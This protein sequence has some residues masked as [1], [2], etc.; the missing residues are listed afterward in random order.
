MNRTEFKKAIFATVVC[1]SLVW[2]DYALYGSLIS[3][4]SVL[5]FPSANYTTQIISAFGVFAVGFL[6]RPLGSLFFGHIGDKYGRRIA[7]FLS[8]ISMSLP[9][10]LIA[11]LPTYQRIGIA[12]TII[13]VIIRAIQGFS[14]GGEAGNAVYL[15]EYSPKNRRGFFGSFEV[16]SAV[17][18]ALLS[19]IVIAI[20]KF[21]I[22]EENFFNWGWRIPFGIG[23]I[24]GIFGTVLRYNVSETP[25][26][27]KN[28]HSEEQLPIY[29]LFKNYKKKLLIA[30]GIDSVEETSLYIF[31]V[32]INGYIISTS[33]LCNFI[34]ILHIIFLVI[35]AI[36][37]LVFALLSDFI[38]RKKILLASSVGA[39]LLSYPI[40]ILLNS[41]DF[42][43]VII[44][45]ILLVIIIGASLGPVSAAV[46]DMFP[47]KISYTGLAFSRNV[48]SA[49]FGGLAP[50]IC[51]YL[52]KFTGNSNSAAL[53]LI[54][55]GLI[56]LISLYFFKEKK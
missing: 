46:V 39:I 12:S 47:T 49:L 29:D 37:T 9:V 10:G 40:F 28:K 22:L 6:M 8:V 30:I 50:T 31:L 27:K 25:A 4:I 20:C 34:E 11:I 56:G 55:S 5:F 13:L 52:V 53:Y 24:I 43:Q 36:L 35:L 54:F 33:N 48:S 32:F 44:S 7:L 41:Q 2:Y 42:W 3:I 15:I 51:I 19:T 26:F 1:N 23:A 16:L 14:L 17:I 21:L 45:Q 18:G 38:G